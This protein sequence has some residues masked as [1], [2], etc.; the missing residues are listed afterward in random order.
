MKSIEYSV[1]SRGIITGVIGSRKL[2]EILVKP[3]SGD[4]KP[5][6]IQSKTK[7]MMRNEGN[8]PNLL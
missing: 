5:P 4:V 3:Y 8:N 2:T 1:A 7:V 6:I